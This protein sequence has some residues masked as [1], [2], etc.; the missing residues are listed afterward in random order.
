MNIQEIKTDQDSDV[1]QDEL[2]EPSELNKP[3]PYNFSDTDKSFEKWK[4]MM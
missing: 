1:T 2:L 4:E 3:D